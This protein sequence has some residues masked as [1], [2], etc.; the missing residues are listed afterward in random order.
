MAIK[1]YFN[2]LGS[3]GVEVKRLISFANIEF[4]VRE[5]C[6]TSTM[7]MP[8][9]WFN[10][11]FYGGGG[12]VDL[13]NSWGSSHPQM[14]RRLPPKLPRSSRPT[15][16]RDFISERDYRLT[17]PFAGIAFAAFLMT[18]RSVGSCLNAT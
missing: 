15:N 11:A 18:S 1:M 12:S 3:F 10:T 13:E 8:M 5:P 17:R 14:G 7:K 6:W 16:C 9:A 4:P 2:R